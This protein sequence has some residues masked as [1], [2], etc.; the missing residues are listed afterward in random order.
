MAFHASARFQ[1]VV[2]LLSLLGIAKFVFAEWPVLHISP[3]PPQPASKKCPFGAI[4]RCEGA[5][6]VY[7]RLC[8]WYIIYWR[9]VDMVSLASGVSSEILYELSSVQVLVASALGTL[10]CNGVAFDAMRTSIVTS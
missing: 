9:N 4:G 8:G 1:P 5:I 6:G 3:R 10:L 7:I 2:I